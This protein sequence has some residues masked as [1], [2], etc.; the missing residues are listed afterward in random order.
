MPQLRFEA[1][2]ESDKAAHFIRVP[3]AVVTAMG[4]GKRVPVNVTLNGYA[5]RSRIAVYG[6]RYYLG[7]RREIRQAAG[8]AAGDQ[9][10][11]ALEFDAELRTVD[12][13]DVLRSVVEAD[14]KTAAAFNKLSYT[15][16]K[17]LVEWVTGAKR[18]ETQRR[19]MEQAMAM[20][21]AR[22]AGR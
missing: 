19:R 21:R 4:Q 12:L 2:L 11:V 17:E 7:V 22:P 13:P 20:L 9:L 18:A 15:H 3:A 10:L 8:V 14:P 5:Y 1:R 16:K 6:G